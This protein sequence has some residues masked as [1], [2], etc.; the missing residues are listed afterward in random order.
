MLNLF[1]LI[2]NEYLKLF[3]TTANRILLIAVFIIFILFQAVYKTSIQEPLEDGVTLEYIENQIDYLTTAHPP[4]YKNQLVMYEFMIENNL[5]GNV[6]QWK[7]YAL[8]EAFSYYQSLNSDTE[9]SPHDT[10]K[11][12][13]YFKLLTNT[14]SNGDWKAYLNLKIE[15][16]QNDSTG[17]SAEKKTLVKSYESMITYGV[18]PGT[19]NWREDAIETIRENTQILEELDFYQNTEQINNESAWTEAYNRMS[20]AQYRLEHDIDIYMSAYQEPDTTFWNVLLESNILVLLIHMIM[21]IFAGGC[22]A[23]EFSRGTI[24]MYLLNPIKRGK[25]FFS[26]YLTLVSLSVLFLCI[27]CVLNLVLTSICVSSEGITAPYLYVSSGIVYSYPALFVFIKTYAISFI[28][29]LVVMT[30]AFM[31]S[32]LLHNS[33][34]AIGVSMA[35]LFGGF[36]L[37]YALGSLKLD[38]GRYLVFSN[39]DLSKISDGTSAFAHHTIG[40]AICVICVYMVIFLLTAYDAFVRQEV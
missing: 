9:L 24:Q 31:I 40:F 27:A 23:Q 7:L 36:A 16:T 20:I 30:F 34:M 8:D 10:A 13:R 38:W 33:S 3:S 37:S 22:I 32:S 11:Y 39:L 18:E 5:Y 17:S 14:I 12:Y 28:P 1:N 25:L 21:V 35:F 29:L 26:K 2:K 6:S 15:Q 4:N 19:G